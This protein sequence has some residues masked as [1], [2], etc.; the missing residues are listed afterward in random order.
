MD[1]KI[2]EAIIIL[3]FNKKVVDDIKKCLSKESYRYYYALGLSGGYDF[4]INVLKEKL[5]N[6]KS[7]LKKQKK[8]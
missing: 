1:K 7:W 5:K 3:K 2:K 6:N 4:A 8:I